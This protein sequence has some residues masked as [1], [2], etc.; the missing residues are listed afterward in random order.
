MNRKQK[1]L[2]GIALGA[3][4]STVAFAPWQIVM[5][6]D[7]QIIGTWTKYSP[8]FLPPDFGD[9]EARLMTQV[10]LFEWTGLAIAYGGVF[11]MLRGK[12]RDHN[13]TP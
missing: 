6:S 8:L 13:T 11:L 2:T 3:L 9:G 5:K 10:M 7:A 4:F 12:P 1:I